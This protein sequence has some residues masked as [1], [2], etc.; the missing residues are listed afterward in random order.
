M[1]E[2]LKRYRSPIILFLSVVL[3]LIIGNL[4]HYQRLLNLM[5]VIGIMLLFVLYF[6]LLDF[7]FKM[8]ITSD[9]SKRGMGILLFLFILFTF[10]PFS[11]WVIYEIY[12]LLGIFLFKINSTFDAVQFRLR[13]GSSFS[14][15]LLFTV[16]NVFFRKRK[17]QQF[18]LEAD[19]N[20]AK[21]EIDNLRYQ[22]SLRDINPHFVESILSTS[23]GR[24]LMGEGRES[25]DMLIRFNQVLRYVLDQ[26]IAGMKTIPL[27]IEWNYFI[28][29]TD[30]LQWKYG[31]ATVELYVDADWEKC[32]HK[33]IPMSL[34]T[35]LENAIKYAVFQREGALVISLVLSHYGFVF[36][37][38]NLFDPV[39]RAMMKS[40]NFG[41]SNLQQRLSKDEGYGVLH[42]EE[43]DNEFIVRLVQNKFDQD[44]N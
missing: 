42:I 28:D 34:V 39:Q 35:I 4:I 11:K 25:A 36:E 2:I 19:N 3:I 21:N 18:L 17:R 43:S 29:L 9:W 37:C 7:N 26:D 41:L 23:V 13:I 40:S 32:H 5:Q 8:V 22:L 14:S 12:P 1:T 6:K 16:G 20:N 15:V 27:K 10:I 24:S 30:I 38:R 33:I 31:D 44:G